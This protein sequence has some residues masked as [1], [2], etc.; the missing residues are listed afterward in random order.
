MTEQ[1]T[2]VG[3]VEEQLSIVDHLETDI[4]TKLKTARGLRQAILRQAFA[5]ELVPRDPDD[6]PASELL[7][8]I[9]AERAARARDAAAA[10]RTVR[11]TGGAGRGGRPRTGKPEKA[12]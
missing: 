1:H 5:G 10:R 9:A 2:I 11:K 4:D 3:S 8:R 6:E 7:K 12:A